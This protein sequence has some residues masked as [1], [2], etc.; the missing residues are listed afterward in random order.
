MSEFIVANSETG[1]EKPW[2]RK[3]WEPIVGLQTPPWYVLEVIREPMPAVADGW[4]AVPIKTQDFEN[5]RLVYSW[6]IE[7]LPPPG[8]DYQGFYDDLIASSVY[9]VVM[10]T[11]GKTGD[12]AAAMTAFLGALMKSEMGRENI[13]ALQAA[14][15][16]LLG[17]ITLT[18][19]GVAEL[20]GLMVKHR[21]SGIYTLEPPQ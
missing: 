2:P 10:S 7:Q 17:Q 15:W 6:Q 4:V 14:I 12:Q 11:P 16:L 21:L 1:E 20:Q 5:G 9:S 19:E 8:P 3:H 18:A 13:P